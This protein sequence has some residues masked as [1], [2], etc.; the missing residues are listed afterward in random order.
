MTENIK[1]AIV[2]GATGL[3]GRELVREL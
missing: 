1:S 2:I 3:V